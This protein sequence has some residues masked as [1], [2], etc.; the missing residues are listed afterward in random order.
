[1]Q[2]HSIAPDLATI[3][4]AAALFA[5]GAARPDTV[6]VNDELL[7]DGLTAA[8]K[9]KHGQCA[10]APSTPVGHSDPKAIF[11]R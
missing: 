4:G 6:D 3:L 5:A 7:G 2:N 9:P 11:G 10:L 8:R 1:M